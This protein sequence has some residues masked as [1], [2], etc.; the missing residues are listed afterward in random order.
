MSLADAIAADGPRVKG[1]PC[2]MGVLLGQDSPLS[3][4][5]KAELRAVM[6]DHAVEGSRI[7]RAL[8]S[9][10]ATVGEHTVNRHRRGGCQ[11]ET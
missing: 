10:G 6:A 7:A 8:T 4:D 5:V 1:P 11:C 3:D 9:L 2:R